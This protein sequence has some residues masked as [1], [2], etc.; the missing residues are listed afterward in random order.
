M[1]LAR[2]RLFRRDP[3]IFDAHVFVRQGATTVCVSLAEWLAYLDSPG[4]LCNHWSLLHVFVSCYTLCGH[5]CP[6]QSQ[7][8]IIERGSSPCCS[9]SCIVPVLAAYLSS[10]EPIGCPEKTCSAPVRRTCPRN[11]LVMSQGV[12]CHFAVLAFAFT[13]VCGTHALS[14]AGPTANWPIAERP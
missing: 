13:L 10:A 4:S 11:C 8:T 3:S 2:W 6:R 5:A 14:R 1:A 12:A 9:F 7:G